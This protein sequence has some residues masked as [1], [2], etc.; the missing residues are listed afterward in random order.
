[1]WAR[2]RCS[3]IS[4]AQSSPTD[5]LLS[6]KLLG[7]SDDGFGPIVPVHRRRRNVRNRGVAAVESAKFGGSNKRIGAV[8]RRWRNANYRP[9]AVAAPFINRTFNRFNS[10]CLATESPRPRAPAPT[11]GLWIQSVSATRTRFRKRNSKCFVK[12]LLIARSAVSWSIHSCLH[13]LGSS[14]SLIAARPY[15]SNPCL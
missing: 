1:M 14:R 5:W 3:A 10:R 12:S 4:P 13:N 6:G 7:T 15:A 2:A 9:D 8:R 11:V